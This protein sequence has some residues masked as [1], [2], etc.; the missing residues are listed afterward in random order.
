[1]I[2]VPI[3]VTGWVE[4]KDIRRCDRC[5]ALFHKLYKECP[6]CQSLDCSLLSESFE[7]KERHEALIPVLDNAP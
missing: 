5:D 4:G 7:D 3:N 2:H 6:K 1:M